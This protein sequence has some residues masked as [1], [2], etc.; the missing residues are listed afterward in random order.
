VPEPTNEHDAN[1]LMVFAHVDEWLH[2][3]Y[4]DRESA[5][6]VHDGGFTVTGA[7]IVASAADSLP[8]QLDLE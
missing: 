7:R 4:I 5:A 6:R 1:A 3:G 2:V 8:V